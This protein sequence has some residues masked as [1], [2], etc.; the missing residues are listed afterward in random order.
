MELKKCRIEIAIA[1]V[2][3]KFAANDTAVQAKMKGS[4]VQMEQRT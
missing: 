3:F 1:A 4:T 2:Y